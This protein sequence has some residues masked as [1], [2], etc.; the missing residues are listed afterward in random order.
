MRGEEHPAST[1]F[2][3]PVS[4]CKANQLPEVSGERPK[5]NMCVSPV[6]DEPDSSAPGCR[7]MPGAAIT[8]PMDAA[9]RREV[10]QLLAS[11]LVA[12][13]LASFGGYGAHPSGNE[14]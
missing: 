4:D 2:R 10:V 3:F 5:V 12:D 7:P 11:A 6:S 14:P 13:F 8:R 1:T 9:T